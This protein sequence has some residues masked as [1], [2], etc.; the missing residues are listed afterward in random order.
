[1]WHVTLYNVFTIAN[2]IILILISI[3]FILRFIYILPK[4]NAGGAGR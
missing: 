1:M 2:N 3:P 4:R